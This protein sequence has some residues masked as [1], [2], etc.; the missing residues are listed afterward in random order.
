MNIE[1]CLESGE[2][3]MLFLRAY[4]KARVSVRILAAAT[5]Y[6]ERIDSHNMWLYE[7]EGMLQNKVAE[8]LARYRAVCLSAMPLCD[9]PIHVR[10]VYTWG[11]RYD[12]GHEDRIRAKR[13]RNLAIEKYAQIKR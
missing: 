8:A 13:L 1:T 5:W 4:P 6:D 7:T 10:L 2:L 12:P 3:L 11:K 9:I